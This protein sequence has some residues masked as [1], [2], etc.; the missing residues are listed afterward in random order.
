MKFDSVEQILT[1][2]IET[3]QAAAD[4]YTDL[5]G[6]VEYKQV[7]EA[8][9]EFAAEEMGHK[10]KLQAVVDGRVLLSS[11]KRVVALKIGDYLVEVE[12]KQDMGF[13]EALMAL[14]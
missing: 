14:H 6:K 11:E 10:R 7:K 1:F 9:L 12:A 4:F 8:F 2:A 13:Q 5:A 3:E